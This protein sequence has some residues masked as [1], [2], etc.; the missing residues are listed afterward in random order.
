MLALVGY[1]FYFLWAKAQ[2][3]PEVFQTE[4]A[5][6]SN[7]VKKT[8]A[9]GSI[10]P[11]KEV[12]IKSRVSGIVEE[13]FVEAGQTVRTG[14]LLARIKIIPNAAGLSQAESNVERAEIALKDAEKDFARN[15]KLL[16]QQV[17]AEAEL[18][19]YTLKLNLAKQDVESAQN[20]L[21]VVK[22]G[23][24]QKSSQ[25][26]TNILSTC[27]GTVLD[28]PVKKGTSVIESNNFNEGTNIATIA[29]MNALMFKGNLDESEVGKIKEGLPINIIIAALPDKQIPARLDFI[30]PKGTDVNGAI[31]FEIKSYLKQDK[32]S[33][34]RAGFSANAEI[35][36]AKKDSVLCIREGTVGQ[37]G[38]KRYVEIMKKDRNFEKRYVKLGISDE[39]NTE[40]L[41]G[42]TI[43]DKLKSSKIEE[44]KK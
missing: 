23:S 14:Q 30:S 22:D 6:V 44:E 34:I 28:V 40:V 4:T 20:A 3:Q 35:V 33:Y 39:I 1:T 38:V 29:D 15:K 18:Q 5:F 2:P 13:I 25:K 7:I 16:E 36:L 8:I 26:L 31:Q 24:T 27:D 19:P 11:V 10:V 43:K 42:I 9:T 32:A 21:Q 37:E 12:P 41:E 17:I